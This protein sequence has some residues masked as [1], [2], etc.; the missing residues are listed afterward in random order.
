MSLAEQRKELDMPHIT[1][2]ASL[3]RYLLDT[4]SSSFSE[5][6]GIIS[7]A[8]SLSEIDKRTDFETVPID[9]VMSI[10]DD[11]GVDFANELVSMISKHTVEDLVALLASKLQLPA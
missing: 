9:W 1:D 4:L 2:K 7:L 8:T 3:E 5:F 6:P 11:L 10:E